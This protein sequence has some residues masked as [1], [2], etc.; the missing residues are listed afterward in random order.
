MIRPTILFIGLR[1]LTA[2]RANPFAALVGWASVAGVALGV[3]ALI[4]VLSVMNGF[5]NELRE[6]LL[7]MTGH[8]R[9]LPDGD[10]PLSWEAMLDDLRRHPGVVAAA[11]YVELQGMLGSGPELAPAVISG[12][13]PASEA[14]LSGLD[15]QML[16]GSLD[17]LLPGSRALVLGRSLALALGVGPGDPLRVMVPFREPGGRVESRLREFTVAGIFE[18][19]LRDHDSVRALVHISDAAALAGLDTPFN[20]IQLIVQ[21]VFAAPR[22]IAEWQSGWAARG[23][24]VPRISDWTVDNATYFRAVRIERVMMTLLLSL[25]V[26]VA[27]FNIVAT[28]VMMVTDR[29]PGIAILRTLGFSRRAV[30]GIFALQG[31]LIGWAGVLAGVGLG[32]LVALR[33]DTLAPQLERWFGF[34]FMPADVYYLTTLPAEL[35]GTD[36]GWVAVIALALTALATLYPA[37]RAAAVAPAEVLRYE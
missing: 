32:V 12:V 20:G 28:L 35:K 17:S 21:D 26:A 7:G 24:G 29:R 1:Y 19:G 16:A 13:D 9:V 22:T 5:E 31:L 34:E 11:P 6:R 15:G 8:A 37:S 10:K 23:G 3:A 33:V 27:A 18:V 14:L 2:Q 4:I 36:V 25:I 30:V